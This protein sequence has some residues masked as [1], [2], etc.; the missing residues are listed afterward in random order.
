MSE[1]KSVVI[2]STRFVRPTAIKEYAHS[3]HRK[4]SKEFITMLDAKIKTT[5]DS[6]CRSNSLV[7]LRP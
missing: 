5:I 1:D 4:V 2:K 7:M 3:Q 6:Y